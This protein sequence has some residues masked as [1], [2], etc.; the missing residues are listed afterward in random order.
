MVN[1]IEQ[2][3][4]QIFNLI[5]DLQPSQNSAYTE[6]SREEIIERLIAIA[7]DMPCDYVEEENNYDEIREEIEDAL[8]DLED[9]IDRAESARYTLRDV[10]YKL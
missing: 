2:I 7:N 10:F 8:S 4:E 5:N 6:L 3:T 1:K 9:A